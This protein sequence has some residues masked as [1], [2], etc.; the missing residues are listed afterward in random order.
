MRLRTGTCTGFTL[1]ELLVVL[2]IVSLVISLTPAAFQ[3]AI[4]ALETKAAARAVA[5][6]FREGR[7]QAIRDNREIPVI[8][9]VDARTVRVGI[10][11]YPAQLS[12]RL[13]LSLLAGRSEFTGG[14]A[15]Q[16]GFFP[17]GTSTGGRVTLTAGGS[18]YDVVVDWLTGLAVIKE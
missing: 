1:I 12:R 11:H 3:R 18:R 17:D 2:L 4:P 9:D 15:G 7:S 14:S 8:I 13:R 6:A 16:I 10:E 5:A